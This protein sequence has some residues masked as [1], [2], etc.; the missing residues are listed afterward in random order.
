MDQDKK[1]AAS[2]ARAPLPAAP[3]PTKMP[4]SIISKE[5]TVGMAVA[6]VF[7]ALVAGVV[8]TKTLMKGHDASPEQGTIAQTP[9]QAAPKPAPAAAPQLSFVQPS[10]PAPAAPPVI[11]DLTLRP[12]GAQVGTTN[13]SP[14]APPILTVGAEDVPRIDIPSTPS[15]GAKPNSDMATPALPDMGPADLSNLKI[16]VTSAAPADLSNP[17]PPVAPEFKRDDAAK[18]SLTLPAEKPMGP[19]D[20]SS[21][22]ISPDASQG[23]T[24]PATPA[25]A[26]KPPLP[27]DLSSLVIPGQPPAAPGVAS[28]APAEPAPAPKTPANK[29][30]FTANPMRE[31]APVP[32]VVPGSSDDPNKPVVKNPVIQIGGSEPKKEPAAPPPPDLIPNE[33]LIVAPKEPALPLKK[34]EPG[35]DK[36]PLAP[37][38]PASTG[39]SDVPLVPAP[40]PKNDALPEIKVV[41]APMSEP[42]PKKDLTPAPPS[43]NVEPIPAKNDSAPTPVPS[44]TGTSTPKAN[45]PAAVLTPTPVDSKTAVDT[46]KDGDFDEDQHTQ[47]PNESFRSISKQYYNSDAYATAL[48]RYNDEHPNQAGY[49]RIPPIWLLEKKYAGDIASGATRTVNFT[50][51]QPAVTPRNDAV[52]TVSDNGEMLADI[53]LKQ[54]GSESAW[55]NIW[56]LNPQLN[57][58]KAVPGGTRLVMPPR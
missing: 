21:L 16:P 45:V 36:L 3:L 35:P 58:A 54:L 15:T 17:M 6:G 13:P 37:L 4:R 52:Y 32:I 24:K 44:A 53:A 43:M 56:R 47:K 25:P 30:V 22:I 23:S 55:Q 50:Q 5:T 29:D 2:P 27:E 14:P 9:E 46:K 18:P 19:G 10:A 28:P 12:A 48:Q 38:P 1:L 26:V 34:D 51:P 8:V 42:L 33:P 41:P 7:I 49:V 20:T 57:P 11:G 39:S 40:L 31:P